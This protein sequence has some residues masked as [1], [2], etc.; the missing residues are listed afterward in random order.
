MHLSAKS[1]VEEIGEGGEEDGGKMINNVGEREN[2]K[3]KEDG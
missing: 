3:S 1:N 2:G